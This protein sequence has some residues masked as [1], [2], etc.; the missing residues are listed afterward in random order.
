VV[1]E[2]HQEQRCAALNLCCANCPTAPRP[3]IIGVIGWGVIQRGIHDVG[4]QRL[5]IGVGARQQ[6]LAFFQRQFKAGIK[7]DCPYPF[8]QGTRRLSQINTGYAIFRYDTAVQTHRVTH[9]TLHINTRTHRF[10]CG[11]QFRCHFIDFDGL[12]SEHGTGAFFALGSIFPLQ[13]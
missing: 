9:K 8:P 1:A 5:N 12:L 13:V 6:Y 4:G 10:A 2:T 3:K 7:V 11:G